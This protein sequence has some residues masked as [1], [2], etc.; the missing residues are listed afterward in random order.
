MKKT[1]MI[2]WYL[3]EGEYQAVQKTGWQ[4]LVSLYARG[5]IYFPPKFHF[6]R[7]ITNKKQIIEKIES[8]AVVVKITRIKQISKFFKITKI[9]VITY[10]D[11]Y[12]ITQ[13]FQW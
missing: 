11:E 12:I 6:S 8:W 13:K 7:I 3:P 9:R 2:I 4:G 1:K 5:E 10:S